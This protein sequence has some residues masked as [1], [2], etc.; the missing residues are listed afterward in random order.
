MKHS[1]STTTDTERGAYEYLIAN[2]RRHNTNAWFVA[3]G[4]LALWMILM[5]V[6]VAMWFK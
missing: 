3:I 6:I 4:L 2:S 5:G 1:N